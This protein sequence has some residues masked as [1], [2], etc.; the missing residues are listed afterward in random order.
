MAL[1]TSQQLV[2]AA[3]I[4]SRELRMIEMLRVKAGSH[5]AVIAN[6]LDAGAGMI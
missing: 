2:S 1:I 5:E 6:E 3:Q 4:E